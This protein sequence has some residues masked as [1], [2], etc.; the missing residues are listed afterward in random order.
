[1]SGFFLTAAAVTFASL[2]QPDATQGTAAS[3][4]DFEAALARTPARPSASAAAPSRSTA[5]R[6][7]RG[8]YLLAPAGTLPAH[9]LGV[10]TIDGQAWRR[11]EEEARDGLLD[12]WAFM[13]KFYG[14]LPVPPGFQPVRCTNRIGDFIFSSGISISPEY[15]K[16][17][18]DDVND[19][20]SLV[21]LFNWQQKTAKAA[22]ARK[23]AEMEA[24][25]QSKGFQRVADPSQIGRIL[26]SPGGSSD[27]DKAPNYELNYG[28]GSIV[29][30]LCKT[31]GSNLTSGPYVRVRLRQ[32][33]YSRKRRS[34][35]Y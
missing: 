27:P 20:S 9:W 28:V 19:R 3:Q 5:S 22:M 18:E 31:Y 30:V 25:Y 23:M 10:G 17:L 16:R 8:G 35:V 32:P 24:F 33:E 2:V 29:K 12:P 21:G 1:M 14:P 6:G 15:D 7:G 26:Y 11:A 34:T 4:D 13:Q